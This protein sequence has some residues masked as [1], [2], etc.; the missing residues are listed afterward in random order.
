MNI[1]E[2]IESAWKEELPKVRE[3]LQCSR[4]SQVLGAAEIGFAA[5]YRAAIRG[6][7]KD[8][9]SETLPDFSDVYTEVHICV[10]GHWCSTLNGIEG[11]NLKGFTFNTGEDDGTGVD[12]RIA[13]GWDRVNAIYELKDIPSPAEAFGEG[14]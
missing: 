10:A 1:D 13:I 8:H 12:L 4:A 3:S 9:T 7:W 2:Q 5:G 14:G 6:L 11:W